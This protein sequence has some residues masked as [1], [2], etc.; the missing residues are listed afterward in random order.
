MA[1]PANT[2]TALC[3]GLFSSGYLT[4]PS[5]QVLI[6][7]S[8]II[9][10]LDQETTIIDQAIAN[11]CKQTKKLEEYRIALI[12]EYPSFLQDK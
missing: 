12:F 5:V 7:N 9:A 1:N 3:V 11:L 2:S 8:L 4:R 10:F 6:L